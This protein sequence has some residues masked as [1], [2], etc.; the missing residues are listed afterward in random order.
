M[1]RKGI[2]M[3]KLEEKLI[4]GELDEVEQP[5]IICEEKKT[6]KGAIVAGVAAAAVAVGCGV[7]WLVGK[8]RDS[9]PEYVDMDDDCDDLDEI[10][11]S[12][13]ITVSIEED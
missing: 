11:I 9:N 3:M 2:K 12:D 1:K 10:T 8:L 13:E 7:K 4:N 5:E 6:P